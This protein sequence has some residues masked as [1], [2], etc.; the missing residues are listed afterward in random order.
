MSYHIVVV[1][2]NGKTAV[3]TKK[4]CATKVEGMCAHLMASPRVVYAYY[5]PT[6]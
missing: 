6:R 3:S 2:K 1:G 5:Q 4:V